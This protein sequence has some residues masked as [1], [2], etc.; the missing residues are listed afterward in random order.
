[1][2]VMPGI[3]I[4]SKNGIMQRIKKHIVTFG[5]AWVV[6]LLLWG[7]APAAADVS[8]PDQ[9]VFD[10]I[11]QYRQAPYDHA[12]SLGF[13][14]AVLESKGILPDTQFPPYVL[15]EELCA[16]ADDANDRASAPETAPVPPAPVRQQMVET[17]AILTFANF[18]PAQVAG[19]FFVE[20]LFQSE[21]EAGEFQYILSDTLT[22]AGVSLTT[23][24]AAGRNAWL[25]SLMLGNTVRTTDIQVLNLVNQ[26]RSEPG[27]IPFYLPM[28]PQSTLFRKWQIYFLQTLQFDPMFFNDRLYACARADVLD[29]GENS[30]DDATMDFDVADQ[31]PVDPRDAYADMCS[32]SVSVASFWQNLADV[33][34]VT[35]L[36]T[37]LLRNE[38]STWPHSAVIFSSLYSEGGAYF[39]VVEGE[40]IDAG[41]PQGTIK[42]P[43]AGV[44]SLYAGSGD[45]PSESSSSDRIYGVLFDDHD[46]NGVYAIGEE[47][48]GHPVHVYD[49]NLTLVTTVLSDNAGHFYLTLE[50]GRYWLFET[51]NGEQD[52]RRRIFL[53]K[54]QF[55]KMGFSPPEPQLVP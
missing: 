11:N 47:M 21:L 1:M 25:F 42:Y 37:F 39:S 29:T 8:I 17:G 33:Q 27:L 46:G 5:T 48:T 19:N 7:L 55:V 32:R 23:G 13:D 3:F 44:V 10:L 15:D 40:P 2:V 50:S 43:G 51:N 45:M 14:P 34:P 28:E 24:T 36:F 30:P 16:A 31:D 52:I 53:D 12:V 18:I 38:I 54:D 9:M 49:E 20:N 4:A 41:D 6:I 26:I 22:H 35:D